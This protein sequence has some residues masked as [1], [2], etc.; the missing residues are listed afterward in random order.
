MIRNVVLKGRTRPPVAAGY[1]WIARSLLEAPN[2]GGQP[3]EFE[4]IEA[5]LGGCSPGTFSTEHA[6]YPDGCYMIH[7][8]ADNH[9]NVFT[10][11]VQATGAGATVEVTFD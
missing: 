7:W 6:Q 5:E 11:P 9:T 8:H 1:N 3:G 4:A 2:L 10:A